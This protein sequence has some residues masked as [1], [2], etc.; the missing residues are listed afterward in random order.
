MGHLLYL[1]VERDYPESGYMLSAL[2]QFLHGNEPGSGF[3]ALASDKGLFSAGGDKPLFW[4][5][6]VKGVHDF[7]A[8]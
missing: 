5:S 7:Y 2:V 8:R 3:Y 6:Q 1:I 4:A